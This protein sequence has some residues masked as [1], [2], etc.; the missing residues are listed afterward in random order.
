MVTVG[1]IAVLCV[2][3]DRL[4]KN[5]ALILKDGSSRTFIKNVIDF[6][7]LENRG[8]AF[9]IMQNARAV[10]IVITVAVLVGVAAY[11]F[12]KKPKNKLLLSSLGLIAGGAVGNLI[13]RIMQG[14]VV[15]FIETTFMDFPVFNVADICV[16]IGVAL[17]ILY[18]LFFD[19]KQKN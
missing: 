15:D 2:V 10:F 3:A 13:D 1:I 11:I 7:Y 16:C 12:V 6:V 18:M 19:G 8:A 5:F 9:G 4:T 14:Y 17:L